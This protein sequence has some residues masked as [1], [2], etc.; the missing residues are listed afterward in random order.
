MLTGRVSRCVVSL[1]HGL[2]GSLRDVIG[3]AC[4]S[5]FKRCS[6]D[7]CQ[8]ECDRNKQC[9]QAVVRN[10]EIAQTD[11]D[12]DLEGAGSACIL[13]GRQCFLEDVCQLPFPLLSRF[14]S[15]R[16]PLNHGPRPSLT[17]CLLSFASRIQWHTVFSSLQLS[18]PKNHC[19]DVRDSS[20]FCYFKTKVTGKNVDCKVSSWSSWST[21]PTTCAPSTQSRYRTVMIA[22]QN[23]GQA[24]PA[25]EES[26]ACPVPASC[27][28]TDCAL[29]ASATVLAALFIV[30]FSTDSQFFMLSTFDRV[31]TCLFTT[32]HPA[33]I[34][35]LHVV[36]NVAL[37]A[38]KLALWSLM[39]HLVC[40]CVI[41]IC[42][43]LFVFFHCT[44]LIFICPLLLFLFLF[45]W[46]WCSLSHTNHLDSSMQS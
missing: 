19:G 43:P 45:S 44:Y 36:F 23:R 25:L 6:L 35:G 12:P 24:C 29:Y 30:S 1:C 5:L 32:M 46:H 37:V 17:C 14:G 13:Y 8:R 31:L 2:S 34:N 38:L 15:V 28:N 21:C 26:R 40:L 11:S 4:L 3:I 7:N 20:S 42:L 22:K 16:R 10:V 9:T 18:N 39:L 33:I 41:R 27:I